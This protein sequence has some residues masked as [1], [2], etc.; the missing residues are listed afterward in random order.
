MRLKSVL[1]ACAACIAL[2]AP[3]AAQTPPPTA[4]S[5]LPPGVTLR[6]PQ[7]EIGPPRDVVWQQGPATPP[8]GRKQPN[9]IVIMVDDMGYNDITLNGGGVA[10]G[11]VPTPNIDSIGR[12][13]VSFSQG[14]TGHGTCAPSRA[15]LMTGRYP[16]RYGFEFTPTPLA[17]ARQV[18]A[19]HYGIFNPVYF[20]DRESE[21]I[22]YAD[23]GV[24][25]DQVML[26]EILRNAGYHTVLFGKWHLGN[27]PKFQPHNRGFNETLGFD[28]GGALFLPRNDPR[29]VNSFQ[30]FDPIDMNLWSILQFY[31]RKDG[32]P[33]F[34]PKRHMTDYL[35]DEA[36]SAI[37]ANRNRPFF[38]FLSYNA[39]HTPL[40]ATKEDYDALPQIADHRMRVYAAMIL[41]LDRNIGRV[42]QKLQEEGLDKDT[43][44][45]FTSDNG[46]AYYIGLPD[47]NRPFRGW[48]Q[49]F[50]E[51]GIRTPFLM[52]WPGVIAPGTNYR[53]PVTHFDIFTTAA[54]VGRANL[55]RDR[56]LDGV[57]LLPFVQGRK[58]GRPHEALFWRVGDYRVV[59]AG[60]WKLHMT[61]LPA[62]AWLYD[63]ASDPT[64]RNNLAESRPDKLAELQALL[65]KHDAEQA[66]PLWPELGMT[67][68]MLDHSLIDPQRPTDEYV[69]WGN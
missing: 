45:M 40:Q 11:A 50:F 60:D 39:P 47:I 20:R 36:L 4:D 68:I 16:T 22:P 14:Y 63:L 21:L 27:S 13:G 23:M 6:S 37:T 43:L 56:V 25:T 51:G 12:D 65:A 5:T 49:T 9:I 8:R 10:D 31:V 24:P 2:A 26:P 48:K 58:T 57:D 3:T 55:P 1:L 28:G 35:T 41:G 15:A 54:A 61:K 33:A 32:G 19:F 53:A 44:V 29:G 7:F 30:G 59:R 18:R 17:F 69:Y 64:E 42:L 34:Q 62:K 38:M 67:A 66:K 46:G 52:R